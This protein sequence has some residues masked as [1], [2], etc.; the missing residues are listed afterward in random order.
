VLEDQWFADSQDEG[1]KF[2]AYFNPITLP[3]IALVFTAVKHSCSRQ[4]QTPNSPASQI[5][6]CIDKRKHG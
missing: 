5:E 2:H 3:T 1:I 6:N 4:V